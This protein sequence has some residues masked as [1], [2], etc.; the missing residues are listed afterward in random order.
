MG[1]D[2][3]HNGHRKR[4]RQSML[5]ADFS[6]VQD[7][8]LLEAL[9]FYSVPMCDTNETAHKLINTFGSLGGVFEADYE[10]LISVSGVGE[11]SAFLIKLVQ[12]ISKETNNKKKNAKQIIKGSMDAA[13]I[14]S[15]IFEGEKDEIMAAMF[16]DNS[17]RVISVKSIAKGHVNSV[18]VDN[19]KL[20]EAAVRCNASSVI[21]AHN[22]PHGSAIPSDADLCM[23][24]NL[25]NLLSGIDIRVI[26]HII[27]A[28]GE[29]CAVS[30][31][32]DS[33][34]FIS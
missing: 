28:D 16:L 1:D 3:I 6:G 18:N 10:D 15:G 26:D 4:L 30:S 32:K 9:L 23:T 5:D 22:H 8:N 25:R 7:N 17:N 11:N 31:R 21:L 12:R 34:K 24:R 14:I 13:R 2:S 33:E 20:L 27:F 29:F 19:R